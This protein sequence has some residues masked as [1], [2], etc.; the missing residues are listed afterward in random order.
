MKG[1]LNTLFFTVCSLRQYP[2]A[3]ALGYS[4]QRHHPDCPFLIG[5]ADQ[6][7]RL[8]ESAPRPFLIVGAESIQVADFQ[9]LVERFNWL[10]V[11]HTLRPF[12]AD[13]FLLE[14][15]DADRLVF[16]GPESWVL[17]PLTNWLDELD[18]FPISLLPQRLGPARDAHWPAERHLL[19]VG[20]YQSE[21]WA[22]RRSPTAER[23]LTWWM[24]RLHEKGWLRL[25]EGY[26]L[27]QL[28]LN[29]VPAFFEGVS[30]FSNPGFGAGYT[31]ADERPVKESGAI[32]SVGNA[33]L[34]LVSWTGL[35]VGRLR[36]EPHLTDRP[37]TAS[38]RA[39]AA[40]YRREIP[41]LAMPGPTFGRPFVPLRT[42]RRRYRFIQPLRRLMAW[43]E[44]TPI[45]FFR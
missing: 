16:L 9:Q 1:R 6:P 19:N 20:V 15:P 28:W 30:T 8:P 24:A 10:E 11:L 22:L 26:G 3:L 33:P 21:A 43:V 31:N 44:Q 4:L 12:F 7:K 17:A 2:Q 34:A 5:L 29:L 35:D 32:G 14:N 23:F 41:A 40:R 42:P 25:C 37:M 39:L 45:P 36:W 18:S 13:Y 38:W 27:D